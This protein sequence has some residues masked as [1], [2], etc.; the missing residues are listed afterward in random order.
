MSTETITTQATRDIFHALMT[1]AEKSRRI[2]RSTEDGLCEP[3]HAAFIV[4]STLATLKLAL[5]EAIDP[6]PEV[7]E[8]LKR[9]LEVVS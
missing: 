4:N 6:A 7:P 2:M 5:A 3:E 1:A 8:S 9:D